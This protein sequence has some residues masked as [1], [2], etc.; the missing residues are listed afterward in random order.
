MKWLRG[1]CPPALRLFN[2]AKQSKRAL[3]RPDEVPQGVGQ[4]GELP[5]RGAVV[6]SQ[7]GR[8]VQLG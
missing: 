7:F 5:A 8:I 3:E 1:V 6:P 4:I 2:D